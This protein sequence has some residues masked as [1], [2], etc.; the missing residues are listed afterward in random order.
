MSPRKPL[1]AVALFSLIAV[2]G[3]L[4][5]VSTN[6]RN[7]GAQPTS[8]PQASLD[9]VMS[10]DGSTA[11]VTLSVDPGSEV[12]VAFDGVISYNPDHATPTGCEVIDGFGAC[13]PESAGA[14]L[15]AAASLDEW[16]Q[17]TDIAELSFTVTDASDIAFTLGTVFAPDNA[18]IEG[19][20]SGEPATL[21]DA[22]AAAA[23]SGGITGII[24]AGDTA[25][26]GTQVCAQ[27]IQTDASQCADVDSRGAYRIDGLA[28]GS[29]DLVARHY[30]DEFAQLTINDVAVIS[31]NLTQ[32]VDG[33]L[34]GA[35]EEASEDSPAS[36]QTGS[37]TP[38]TGNS[39]SGTVTDASGA[40][41][42]AALVCVEDVAIGQPSC[43]GTGFDGEY[44][45]SNLP[46]G[47]Y[48]ATV[49]DPGRRYADQEGDTFGLTIDQAKTGVDFTLTAG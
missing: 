26:F 47:N 36:A 27:S 23:G 35:D 12:V 17:A 49:T 5:M 19:A 15:F 45:I 16:S 3:V 24:L 43:R 34:L 13:N 9:V 32:G 48:V 31:P 25:L 30:S 10:D 21:G 46:S 4:A 7:A 38:G 6:A 1:R 18:T 40:A 2:I 20:T 41:V 44:V 22:P 14:I 37:S 11:T 42:P 8:A 29:Y 28:T 39:V 33:S